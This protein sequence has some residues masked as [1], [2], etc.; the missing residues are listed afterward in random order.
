MKRRDF[1]VGAALLAGTMARGRAADIPAPS[2]EGLDRITAY[3]GQFERWRAA[4]ARDNALRSRRPAD[5][6]TRSPAVD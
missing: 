3:F 1:L 2:P 6:A 5:R 4:K